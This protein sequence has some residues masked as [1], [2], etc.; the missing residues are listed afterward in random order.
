MLSLDTTCFRQSSPLSGSECS[1]RI[2]LEDFCCFETI[3]PPSADKPSLL[4]A[5]AT[6]VKTGVFGVL[7]LEPKDALIEITLQ[8]RVTPFL[9][10]LD[11]CSS[12]PRSG[13]V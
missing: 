7:F 4:P 1:S 9:L 6:Q 2:S 3:V 13:A 12:R 8:L 10:T 11:Q 5:V